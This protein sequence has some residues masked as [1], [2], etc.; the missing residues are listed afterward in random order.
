MKKITAY[1]IVKSLK[2]DELCNEVNTLIED[3]FQP[4][5]GICIAT[6]EGSVWFCQALVQYEE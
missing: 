4:L 2:T 6:S 5:G 3:G 1:T